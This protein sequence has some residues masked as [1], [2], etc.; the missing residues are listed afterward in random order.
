MGKK[1]I[2]LLS[3]FLVVAVI[4]SG[5]SQEDQSEGEEDQ[6]TENVVQSS[7]N[8]ENSN[9]EISEV[10]EVSTK[11]TSNTSESVEETEPTHL[12]KEF[13]NQLAG[14]FFYT[15]ESQE[16]YLISRK[17]SVDLIKTQMKTILDLESHLYQTGIK[18]Y[19]DKLMIFIGQVDKS[20]TQ[21]NDDFQWMLHTMMAHK[22]NI[23]TLIAQGEGYLKKI[24]GK[25]DLDLENAVIY[26][27]VFLMTSNLYE[28]LNEYLNFLESLEAYLDTAIIKTFNEDYALTLNQHTTE[29][30]SQELLPKLVKVMKAYDQMSLSYTMISSGDY[31]YM[32]SMA[33]DI[34]Q[35]MNQL[36]ELQGLEVFKDNFLDYISNPKQYLI[37]ISNDVQSNQSF[38]LPLIKKAYASSYDF[39]EY[40]NMTEIHKFIY[41]LSLNPNI[42]EAELDEALMALVLQEH[43]VQLKEKKVKVEEEKKAVEVLRPETILALGGEKLMSLAG[44]E[45]VYEFVSMEGAPPVPIKIEK[46][47]V[48]NVEK[49]EVSKLHEEVHQEIINKEKR[50]KM[51]ENLTQMQNSEAGAGASLLMMFTGDLTGDF[52]Y[53]KIVKS[54]T[55]ALVENKSKMK[56]ETFKSLDNLLQKDLETILGSKKTAFAN[57]FLN[58]SAETL[59]NDFSDWS[60]NRLIEKI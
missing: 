12:E 5:C 4:I 57:K 29:A 20:R 16:P 40:K 24:E 7:E 10:S 2:R 14:G 27:E 18:A 28:G 41:K 21:F 32:R 52:V 54:F 60:I 15:P 34:Q 43:N 30:F 33:E 44:A 23:E 45:K 9:N 25:N 17:A 55:D 49:I 13:F 22:T 8:E 53:N 6:V 35:R 59:V 48:K 11:S 19:E 46:N 1:L 56:E 47:E 38:K 36:D 26:N 50:E 3:L 37:V 39:K 42:S 51:I 31:F 58:A